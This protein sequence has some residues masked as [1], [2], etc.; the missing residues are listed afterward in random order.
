MGG[1]TLMV[2]GCG[3][4][5]RV[6]TPVMVQ[7]G[8]LQVSQRPLPFRAHQIVQRDW[9]DHRHRQGRLSVYGVRHGGQGVGIGA[10]LRHV[11][12]TV[13]HIVDMV[14]AP[15]F[16]QAHLEAFGRVHPASTLVQVATLTP[17]AARVKV[18]ATAVISD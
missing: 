5:A 3:S 14:D 7:T 1:Y 17:T 10:G 8:L 9:T 6:L 13:V 18:E 11:V 16:A 2:V 15:L 4:G 12:R